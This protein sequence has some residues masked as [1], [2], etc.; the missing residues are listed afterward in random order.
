MRILAIVLLMLGFG[1]ELQ[2]QTTPA[3]PLVVPFASFPPFQYLN[4]DGQRSGFMVDLAELIGAEIG[5]PIA[6]LDVP[7]ARA[8]VAAQVRGDTQLLPGVVQLPPLGSTNVYSTRVAT[9]VLRPAVQVN[10]DALIASGVLSGQRVGVV[11][12]SEGAS[13]PVLSANTKVEFGNPHTALMQLLSGNVDALLAPP[14]VLY[15]IARKARLEGRIAFIGEPL[16]ISPRYIAL[17]NSRSELL[18]PINA[19]IAR[20]ESD[21]RLEAIRQRHNITLPPPCTRRADGWD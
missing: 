20:I 9:D 6:Y 12:P 16:R 4:E 15:A 11:P 21:G 2:S 5:V 1:Q 10:N 7:N 8:W 3:E 17:H 14:A 19:A 18:A 13:E